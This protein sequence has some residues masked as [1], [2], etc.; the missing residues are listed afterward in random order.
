MST[1]FQVNGSN[2]SWDVGFSVNVIGT[3]TDVQFQVAKDNLSAP[4]VGGT[5]YFFDYSVSEISNAPGSPWIYEVGVS[6]DTRNGAASK[7]INT[8]TGGSLG[9]AS[10]SGTTGGYG[11]DCCFVAR[12]IIID[13]TIKS[14]EN[15]TPQSFTDYI[16][17]TASPEPATMAL[18]GAGLLA[19]GGLLRRRKLAK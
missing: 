7:I 12:S 5:N 9:T 10:T 19:L 8:A 4:L 11:V 17:S 13:E 1:I 2:A 15:G 14:F 6:S 18:M 16:D 3:T